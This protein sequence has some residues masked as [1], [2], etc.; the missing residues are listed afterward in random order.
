MKRWTVLLL[1]ILIISLLVP[2]NMNVHAASGSLSV[3]AGSQS[4]TVGNTVKVTVTYSGGNNQIASIWSN[5]SYNANAFSYV[6]TEYSGTDGS[7]ASG[8]AGV[9][10][11]LFEM[12]ASGVLA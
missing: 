2:I 12:P 4:V 9:V 6:E 5:I 3:S 8:Q 1:T 10:G 7:S 11:A